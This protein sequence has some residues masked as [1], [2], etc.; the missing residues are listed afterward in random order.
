MELTTSYF[1]L[2]VKS[3]RRTSIQPDLYKFKLLMLQ[4]NGTSHYADPK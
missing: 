1:I 4:S 2:S 3:G